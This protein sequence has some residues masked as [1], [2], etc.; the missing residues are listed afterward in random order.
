MH[1][2][3]ITERIMQIALDHLPPGEKV[4]VSDVYLVLGEL[5]SIVDDSVQFYWEI[6]G[7]NNTAVSTATLHFRR[8]PTQLACQ[9]CH[10][11]YHPAADW[12]CPTCGSLSVRV[13]AGEEFY[14]EAI[15]VIPADRLNKGVPYEQTNH[16]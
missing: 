5:S 4:C 8:V 1:E 14:V 6:I 9:N 3:A 13:T 10:H 16:H 11:T 15:E 7:Q 12:V 2:L